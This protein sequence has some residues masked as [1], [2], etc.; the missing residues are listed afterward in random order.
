MFSKRG[1]GRVRFLQF[2]AKSHRIAVQEQGNFGGF[3]ACGAAKVTYIYI[4]ILSILYDVILYYIL[5]FMRAKWA[6][7]T[8]FSSPGSKLPSSRAD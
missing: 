3:G 4:H 1:S 6:A 7:K 8:D 5:T 2:F